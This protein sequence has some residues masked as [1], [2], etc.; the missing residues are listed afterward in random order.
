MLQRRSFFVLLLLALFLSA[1]N[2]NQSTHA[3]PETDHATMVKGLYDAFAEGDVEAVLAGLH[4]E[5]EWLEAENFI[6]ADRNPYIG[7]EA[8]VNGVFARLGAE[9]EYWNLVDKSFSNMD[10]DH[11]LVTGRYQAKL[12]RTG[13]EIDAQF[14]HVWTLSEGVATRFQQYVDT[15]QVAKVYHAEPAADEAENE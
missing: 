4:P 15:K 12:K 10:G 8:V 14:A 5:V 11:V 3:E 2:S 9:W 7:H 1:C 13:E 6:Y